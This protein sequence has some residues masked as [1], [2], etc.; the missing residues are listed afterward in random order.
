[1]TYNIN[2]INKH[3]DEQMKNPYTTITTKVDENKEYIEIEEQVVDWRTNKAY[4]RPVLVEKGH[5]GV[6]IP[7]RQS[8]LNIDTSNVYIHSALPTSDII[9]DT[10]NIGMVFLIASFENQNNA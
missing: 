7:R 9:L 8:T 3:G 4:T 1:M 6:A 2:K 5:E 10:D